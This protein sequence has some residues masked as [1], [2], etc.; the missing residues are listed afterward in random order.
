M[1]SNNQVDN[2]VAGLHTSIGK[3]T[4]SPTLPSADIDRLMRGRVNELDLREYKEI[5]AKSKRAEA[6]KDYMQKYEEDKL[7]E[8]FVTR[9]A[10][11]IAEANATPSLGESLQWN[12]GDKTNN[13]QTRF[14]N[15]LT[16]VLRDLKI[17]LLEKNR[18]YGD[19]ALN[20]VRMFSK[21][22][23]KEQLL[24]R[25]D[26][27]LSRIQAGELDENEDVF[28]DLFGYIAIYLIAKRREQEF[29]PC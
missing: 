2:A 29:N 25:I 27:K 7:K 14:E 16:V 20:P 24:V 22:S 21:A 1:V 17:L 5:E 23:A 15:D 4:F 6:A 12:K 18:M 3:I 28:F 26:D 11:K 10:N 19:S 8:D 9:L 13:A